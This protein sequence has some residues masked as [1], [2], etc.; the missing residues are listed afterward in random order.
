MQLITVP[1]TIKIP[2]PVKEVDFASMCRTIR[3]ELQYTQEEMAR[4]LGVAIRTYK[5]WESGER[6]PFPH[7]VFWLAQMHAEL[8]TNNNKETAQ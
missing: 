3:K 4:F 5:Y 2:P 1:S 6:A 8:E 7:I